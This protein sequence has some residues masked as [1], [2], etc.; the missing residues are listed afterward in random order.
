MYGIVTY[1]CHKK[2]PNIGKYTMH[3]SYGYLDEFLYD[4]KRHPSTRIKIGNIGI[5]G[6]FSPHSTLSLWCPPKSFIF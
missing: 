5:L 3:G 6:T 2:Q 4:K 1:K